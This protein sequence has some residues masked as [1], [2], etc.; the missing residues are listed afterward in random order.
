LEIKIPFT[1]NTFYSEFDSEE[2]KYRAILSRDSLFFGFF[3][4]QDHVIYHDVIDV[5]DL[6]SSA[7]SGLK[8]KDSIIAFNNPLFCTISSNQDGDLHNDDILRFQHGLSDLDSYKVMSDDCLAYS[9]D[10]LYGIPKKMYKHLNKTILDIKSYHYQSILTNYSD[11]THKGY[12]MLVSLVGKGLNIVLKKDSSLLISNHYRVENQS[13]FY[14]YVG[15]IFDQFDLKKNNV[16]ISV[17]GNLNQIK[18]DEFRF[19]KYFGVID[20]T[21]SSNLDRM[22]LP[23]TYLNQC[24]L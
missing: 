10:V 20:D 18:W 5:D 12:E 4:I 8:F 3:T 9:M 19:E 14:Y 21:S 24:E 6:D 23:L 2:L 17:S 13:D 1:R 15:L 16:Q 22:S 7:A 11:S